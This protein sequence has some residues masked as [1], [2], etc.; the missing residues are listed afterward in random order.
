MLSWRYYVIAAG[1]STLAWLRAWPPRPAGSFTVIPAE[2][3]ISPCL[4]V[5]PAGSAMQVGG[6]HLLAYVPLP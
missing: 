4:Y 5:D 3:Y 6:V 2:E 1:A